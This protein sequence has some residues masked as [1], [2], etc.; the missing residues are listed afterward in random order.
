MN[1]APRKQESMK[2]I[3]S[4]ISEGPLVSEEAGPVREEEEEGEG[5]Q[6]TSGSGCVVVFDHVPEA[7]SKQDLTD[8]IQPYGQVDRVSVHPT[9][10]TYTAHVM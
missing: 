8:L 10:L 5:S 9:G 1:T 7:V 2:S 3:A 6:E 4:F